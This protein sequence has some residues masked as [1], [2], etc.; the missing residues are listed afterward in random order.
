MTRLDGWLKQATRGLSRDS[1]A[2]VQIEIREHYESARAAALSAGASSDEADGL[3][4]GALGDAKT[5]NCE[6]RR[7][8]LTSA[9]A[10]I[11]REGNWEARAVC[12]RPLLRWLCLA[13][14]VATLAGCAACFLT[15][16]I[17]TAWILLAGSMA[18]GLVLVPPFL[19]VYT[20]ARGRVF[21]FAKWVV[22]MGTLVFAFHWSWL[23][24]S[25]LWPLAWVEW[26]RIS[27]RRKLPVAQWPK[28]LY[29]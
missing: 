13:I 21:R 25:C 26:T 5:A 27:I 8:L 15:G 20:P 14:P 18:L 12:S 28:Q 17:S 1:A 23:L 29:L 3:A 9:E 11:L 22:L 19:P 2:Q 6:Y 24:I 4:V 10:R 16:A 7:V